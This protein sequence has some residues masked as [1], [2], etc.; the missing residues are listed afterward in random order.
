MTTVMTHMMTIVMI[1]YAEERPL[2][3]RVQGRLH[4]QYMDELQ[5]TRNDDNNNETTEEE[6]EDIDMTFNQN[7]EVPEVNPEE[8]DEDIDMPSNQN[9]EVK[10]DNPAED[11]DAKLEDIGNVTKGKTIDLTLG[12]DDDETKVKEEE[13]DQKY[14]YIVW[15]SY[16][17][18]GKKK[19]KH[20]DSNVHWQSP[21]VRY[22]NKRNVCRN[23]S[24]QWYCTSCGKTFASAYS[25][26]AHIECIH[27]FQ[28]EKK[29]ECLAEG[30]GL[31]YANRGG[32]IGHIK[33]RHMKLQFKCTVCGKKYQNNSAA[34]R[35][36]KKCRKLND[37]G[38]I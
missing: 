4:A 22:V 33:R 7:T 32:V 2:R 20:A 8:E 27:I 24:N 21:W 29:F 6:D 16:K 10:E 38:A 1:I 14:N 37:E 9:T 26:L 30:C 25:L 5:A 17:I 19:H 3:R 36:A 31:T 28:G 35:C 15:E 13:V 18:S 23:K 12:D 11:E 34:D